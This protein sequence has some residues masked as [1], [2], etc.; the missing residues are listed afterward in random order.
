[1]EDGRWKWKIDGQETADGR[2]RETGDGRGEGTKRDNVLARKG[3]TYR[4]KI[5]IK[6]NR[7]TH[8]ATHDARGS[9]TL[10][11]SWSPPVAP[12]SSAMAAGC[13]DFDVVLARSNRSLFWRSAPCPRP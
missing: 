7:T 4:A 12:L 1:M 10:S 11:D 3:A 13:S 5:K 9:V 8:D 2:R 6:T